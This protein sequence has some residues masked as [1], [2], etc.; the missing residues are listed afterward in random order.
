MKLR[1]NLKDD[2]NENSNHSLL[3]KDMIMQIVDK[4]ITIDELKT[5][6]KKMFSG[7][8]KGVVDIEKEIMV[9]D[10]EVHADEE[11]LLLENESQQENLWG[12]NIYPEKMGSEDWIEFD[13]MINLRPSFGNSTR[14]VDD[15]K[16]QEKIIKIVTKLIT[17]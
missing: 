16:I 9:V 11:S 12:I 3:L 8:V 10:A 1:K 5:M 17:Q 2:Y 15:Q 7:L 14:G 4:K 6:S 13:S